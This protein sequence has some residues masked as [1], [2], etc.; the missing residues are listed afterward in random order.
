MKISFKNTIYLAASARVA[1]PTGATIP[2]DLIP[3]RSAVL[4][5]IAIAFVDVERAVTSRVTGTA[6]AREIVN[7]ILEDAIFE[8]E[9]GKQKNGVCSHSARGTVVAH[10][11]TV[12]DV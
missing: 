5:G 3:T 9:K 10:V 1:I 6:S 7:Q 2:V 11:I 8:T 12:V 4:T